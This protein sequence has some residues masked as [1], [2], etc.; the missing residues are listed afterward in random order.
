MRLQMT[1]IGQRLLSD[2]LESR[3]VIA[4]QAAIITPRKMVL[5]SNA[6]YGVPFYE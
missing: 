5:R 1:N 6:C 4:C 2:R 3:F